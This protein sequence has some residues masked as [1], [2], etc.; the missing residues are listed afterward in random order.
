[1]VGGKPIESLRALARAY[2]AFAKSNPN[3]YFLLFDLRRAPS[4][5]AKRARAG[6]MQP[7]LDVLADPLGERE[8]DRVARMFAP[9]L[10]GFVAM[11]LAGAMRGGSGLGTAF[12]QGVE[13]ILQQVP[14]TARAKAG[15]RAVSRTGTRR[16]T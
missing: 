3:G 16:A 11:E 13:A 7:I 4:P 2:R 5:E 12:E 1:M 10:H 14:R 8:A 6:A 9:Y 15:P